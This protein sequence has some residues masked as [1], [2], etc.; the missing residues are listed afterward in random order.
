MHPP[1]RTA[2][3]ARL[4][5]LRG[6]PAPPHGRPAPPLHPRPSNRRRNHRASHAAV[7]TCTYDFMI[8]KE[9]H[10]MGVLFFRDLDHGLGRASKADRR[11]RRR[12]RR[13]S[14]AGT[15]GPRWNASFRVARRL[16]LAAGREELAGLALPQHHDGDQADEPDFLASAM[17]HCLITVPQRRSPARLVRSCPAPALVLAAAGRPGLPGCERRAAG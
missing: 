14:R 10:P 7:V 17:P 15:R 5:R 11:N 3:R 6:A 13:A 4:H 8:T 16:A 2:R 12:N 1:A 9:K